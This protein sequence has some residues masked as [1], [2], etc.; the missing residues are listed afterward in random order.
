MSRMSRSLERSQRIAAAAEEE[1]R[2]SGHPVI[3][4]EHLFLALFMVGGPAGTVL[5]NLGIDLNE[6][7]SAADHAR[8]R[9]PNQQAVTTTPA[10]AE[11][12]PGWTRQA[13][14]LSGVYGRNGDDR[15]L[16]LAL[17]EEPSGAVI[18]VLGELGV[19]ASA[20]RQATEAQQAEEPAHPRTTPGAGRHA[21]EVHGY[22]PVPVADV[23]ALVADPT[24]R[25]EWAGS[26][27]SDGT[28][29]VVVTC[30]EQSLIEWEIGSTTGAESPAFR[31]V[32]S[33]A[34]DGPGTRLTLSSRW[35]RRRGVAAVRQYTL[36]PLQRLSVRQMLRGKH[37]AIS[38][39]L[40]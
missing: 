25:S 34:P 23:W 22:V 18:A 8:R 26:R 5:T 32:I 37:Q 39:R 16:L 4:A 6:A 1:C 24:R 3:D 29:H 14:R 30:A 20:A 33:L 11:S 31:L 21:V 27:E 38:R 36:G 15:T 17:L 9:A 10:T 40:V 19:S 7:R 13:R 12:R 35:P 2:R 28:S